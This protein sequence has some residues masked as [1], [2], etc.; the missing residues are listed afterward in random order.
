MRRVV[1]ME[2]LMQRHSDEES[3]L[4]AERQRALPDTSSHHP[5]TKQKS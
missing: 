2:V 5:L 1:G 3:P 4:F